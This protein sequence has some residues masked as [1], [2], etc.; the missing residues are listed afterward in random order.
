MIKKP[1]FSS[2]IKTFFIYSTALFFIFSCGNNIN[3]LDDE[4]LEN[5][6]IN[7]EINY[8]ID[9]DKLANEKTMET[10]VKINITPKDSGVTAIYLFNENTNKL[11]NLIIIKGIPKIQEDIYIDLQWGTYG[12]MSYS[13]KL[14]KKKY[15]LKV[16]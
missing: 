5:I 16:K 14:F 13:P 4:Y 8:K 1:L 10:S 7:N 3:K 12:N 9:L 6:K 2:K 15:I 11:N